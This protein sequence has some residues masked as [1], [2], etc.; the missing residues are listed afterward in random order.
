[1]STFTVHCDQLPLVELANRVIYHACSANFRPTSCLRLVG[2]RCRDDAAL[3]LLHTVVFANYRLVDLHLVSFSDAGAEQLRVPAS[4]ESLDV[5]FAATSDAAIAH[6]LESALASVAQLSLTLPAV[7]RWAVPLD[8][9]ALFR[10]TRLVS[11]D[12]RQ[13]PV[14]D[15]SVARGI[16]SALQRQTLTVLQ[17]ACPIGEPL[18][19]AVSL[20]ASL[21]RVEWECTSTTSAAVA[22]LCRGL[23]RNQS[24]RRLGLLFANLDAEAGEAVCELVRRNFHLI[25]L[26]LAFSTVDDGGFHAALVDAVECNGTLLS[27]SVELLAKPLQARLDKILKRNEGIK[28]TR[29]RRNRVVQKLLG[30]A[31]LVLPSLVLVEIVQNLEEENLRHVAYARL[32]ALINA[33][34]DFHQKQV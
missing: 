34:C 3:T 20:S 8:T 17:L 24:L 27:V 13:L 7:N 16:V 5:T 31:P 32:M 14:L 28:W 1:M 26:D 25:V 22:T 11:L 30:L 4:V 19:S 29:E 23:I 2:F 12:L 6:V 21:R 9:S 15:A 33:I 10:T 18:L